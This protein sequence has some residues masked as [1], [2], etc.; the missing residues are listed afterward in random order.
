ML[1]TLKVVLGAGVTVFIGALSLMTF[2]AWVD[3]LRHLGRL[4]PGPVLM[5]CLAFAFGAGLV[6]GYVAQRRWLF[7]RRGKRS[8]WAL[9]G[10]ATVV[11]LAAAFVHQPVFYAVGDALYVSETPQTS[12]GI[13]VLG[14]AAE[15]YARGADLY[16]QG[17]GAQVLMSLGTR[18]VSLLFESESIQ[19]NVD[20]IRDYVV[21]RGVPQAAIKFFEAEN[22]YQEAIHARRY[23]EE[24]GLKSLLVVSSPAHMQ[25]VK[26]IFDHLVA[27]L[28]E[29][30]Y[31][32]VPQGQSAF[33]RTW[34]EDA[35]SLGR[36]IYEYLSIPYYWLRYIVL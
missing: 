4:L 27:P 6:S 17:F 23:V 21:R 35:F 10:L 34:W 19:T 36:V 8:A 7:R 1:N 25:R 20:A 3:L 31:V 16:L 22:T 18:E 13:W 24:S 9:T 14:T 5:F 28:A 30:R 15:R 11:A 29:V 12:D 26:M 33:K 2:V 32:P